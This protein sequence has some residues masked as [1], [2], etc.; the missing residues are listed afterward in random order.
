MKEPLTLRNPRRALP[1]LGQSGSTVTLAGSLELRNGANAQTFSIYGTYTDAS[2][3]RRLRQTM[4][5][6]GAVTITAEGLGTGATGNT[7]ALSV[8]GG[9]TF[10]I[11]ATSVSCS[12]GI[13]AGA[14]AGIYWAGRSVMASPSDGV[15]GLYNSAVTDFTRLQFGGATSSF[16]ALKRSTTTIQAVLADDSGFSAFQTLYDR[17][18]SGTPEGAVTAPVGTTYHRTDGGAGTSLYVKESGA[19]NTGWVA[20]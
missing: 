7:M 13:G 12:S 5:T 20:K 17:F 8:S 6:G 19:G 14:G 3:Y 1:A 10:S 16:P 18:G 4:T 15:I 9:V 2:N 11:G